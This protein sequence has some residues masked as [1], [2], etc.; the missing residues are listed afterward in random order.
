MKF[1]FYVCPSC[2]TVQAMK[3]MEFE[4]HGREYRKCPVCNA[5]LV[6]SQCIVFPHSESVRSEEE[7]YYTIFGGVKG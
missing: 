4:K 3:L 5:Y 7:L 1:V 6:P 2:G